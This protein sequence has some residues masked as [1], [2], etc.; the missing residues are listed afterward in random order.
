MRE[1]SA[2]QAR[3]RFHAAKEN[4]LS[5]PF[6]KALDFFTKARIFA[7]RG[8]PICVYTRGKWVEKP[9]R[10]YTSPNNCA[11]NPAFLDLLTVAESRTEAYLKAAEDGFLGQ[12]EVWPT[13]ETPLS[14][15]PS[16]SRATHNSACIEWI[17]AYSCDVLELESSALHVPEIL[18]HINALAKDNETLHNMLT[19][20]RSS[21]TQPKVLIS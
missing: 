13:K 10:T 9:S 1:E 8:A 18:V 6:A 7:A 2:A 5:A 16:L 19:K 17:K 21:T 11:L 12:D 3:T 20:P 4:T 15:V 14:V